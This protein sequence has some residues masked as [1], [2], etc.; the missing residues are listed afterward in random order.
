MIATH[1]VI[2]SI[3]WGVTGM[4]HKLHMNKFVFSADI[5]SPTHRSC[6]LFWNCQHY[7]WMLEVLDNETPKSNL[8]DI[9]SWMKGNLTAK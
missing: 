5:S 4:G 6:Y 1:A 2:K 3:M 7:K 8:G 9:L